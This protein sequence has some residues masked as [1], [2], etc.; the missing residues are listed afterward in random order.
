MLQCLDRPHR[1]AFVLGEVLELSG[2]EAAEILEIE[3]ALFRKRLQLAREA[4]IAFTRSYCGLVT[5]AAS[6]HCNQR[7]SARAVMSFSEAQPLQF[8]RRATSFHEARDLVRQVDDARS[9]LA[10]YRTSAPRASTVD[11]A[12]RL[13]ND[14]IPDQ[15]GQHGC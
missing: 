2:P 10:L 5:D 11:F 13:V 9:A 1:I 15:D 14:I 8:A 12:Q 6:C 3:P 4:V 7:V